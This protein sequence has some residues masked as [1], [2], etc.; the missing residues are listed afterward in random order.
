[1]LKGTEIRESIGFSITF[2]SL[3]AFQLKGGRG[4]AGTPGY[5]YASGIIQ[6][7]AEF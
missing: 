7:G 3:V 1:M 5:V 2:L 6:T 4:G